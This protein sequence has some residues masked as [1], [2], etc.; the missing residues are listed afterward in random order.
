MQV[1]VTG[2]NYGG[3]LLQGR[4]PNGNVAVGTWTIPP[5]NT[6]TISCFDRQNSAI[7]HANT[8]AKDGNAVYTWNPP[9]MNDSVKYVEFV[10]TV[11]QSRGMYWTGLRSGQIMTTCSGAVRTFAGF[12]MVVVSTLLWLAAF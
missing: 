7:T 11:A 9:P 8:N 1:R 2:P 3:L 5:T 12:A 6:K 4:E 10:A